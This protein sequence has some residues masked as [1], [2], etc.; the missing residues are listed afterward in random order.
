MYKLFHYNL[1]MTAIHLV[2]LNITS[3]QPTAYEVHSV[4]PIVPAVHRK[5]FNVRF[6]PVC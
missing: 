4:E 3:N 2:K 5:S 6:F 1:T